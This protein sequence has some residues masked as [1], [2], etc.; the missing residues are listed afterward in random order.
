MSSPWIASHQNKNG[1]TAVCTNDR[2]GRQTCSSSGGRVVRGAACAQASCC[3]VMHVRLISEGM[4][5]SMSGMRGKTLHHA[6]TKTRSGHASQGIV[7][8]C[9]R[10][11]ST[12][13]CRACAYFIFATTVCHMTS[14]YFTG[15]LI[16]ARVQKPC[17]NMI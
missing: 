6:L 12:V 8:A 7:K 14:M 15:K 4:A 10:T 16:F 5:W 2:K 3:S 9:Q 11:C 13:F 17:S 1:L